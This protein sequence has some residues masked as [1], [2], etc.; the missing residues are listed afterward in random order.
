MSVP[1][2]RTVCSTCRQKPC[3]CV[4]DADRIARLTAELAEARALA[5]RNFEYGARADAIGMQL[6]RE[7][8]TA[9]AEA[10][11]MRVAL[12]EIFEGIGCNSKYGPG[13]DTHCKTIA[14]KALAAL[15]A[16]GMIE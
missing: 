11:A 7:R 1:T 2:R 16:E 3:A 8:D 6:E 9:V 15:D 12:S 4:T 10:A 14:G 5:C 13:C